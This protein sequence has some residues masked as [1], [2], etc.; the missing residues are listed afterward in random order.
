MRQIFD[1]S[2]A[3]P[4]AD[5]MAVIT[6]PDPDAQRTLI[7]PIIHTMGLLSA[8]LITIADNHEKFVRLTDPE[9]ADADLQQLVRFASRATSYFAQNIS[10]LTVAETFAPDEAKDA[11]GLLTHG[12]IVACKHVPQLLWQ[13]TI[14]NAVAK[15]FDDYENLPRGAR[16][17]QDAMMD[18]L[19]GHLVTVAPDET[20]AHLGTLADAMVSWSRKQPLPTDDDP[21]PP[22]TAR[23]E[24]AARLIY[25]RLGVDADRALDPLTKAA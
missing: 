13:S 3:W 9:R 1:D 4:T 11:C 17:D 24:A 18:K 8:H 12:A 2:T 20:P 10:C 14:S 6:A 25:N 7:S 15:G 16:D 21:R 5:L 22:A 19:I 23:A